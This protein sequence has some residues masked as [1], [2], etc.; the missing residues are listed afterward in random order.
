MP[1][2]LDNKYLSNV[3]YFQKCCVNTL[4]EN[5]VENEV[6]FMPSSIAAATAQTLIYLVP[7]HF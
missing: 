7:H 2:D 6:A 5:S 4:W 1:K 3:Y